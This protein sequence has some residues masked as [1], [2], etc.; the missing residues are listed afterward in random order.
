MRQIIAGQLHKIIDHG[1]QT[2]KKQI[3]YDVPVFFDQITD[4]L[5]HLKTKF[6]SNDNEFDAALGAAVP[7]DQDLIAAAVR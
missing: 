7:G 3:G 6:L 5:N 2:T 4:F 1:G